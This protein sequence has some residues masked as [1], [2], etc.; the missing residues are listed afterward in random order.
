MKDYRLTF[1][2]N[3]HLHFHFKK[4]LDF[5]SIPLKGT[6]PLNYSFYYY[7]DEDRKMTWFLISN[8]HPESK[9]LPS[10][11]QTDY[12]LLAEGERTPDEQHEMLKALAS[13]PNVNAAFAVDMSEVKN[14]GYFLSD[15]EIHMIN[16]RKQSINV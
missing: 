2:I 10:L 16:I 7:P 11:K 15:L 12:F 6:N 14:F 3:K 5:Q 8:H 9:L 4:A 13:I 1:L